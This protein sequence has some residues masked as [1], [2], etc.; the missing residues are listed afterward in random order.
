M[1]A[2]RP[3]ALALESRGLTQ[4]LALEGEG[5]VEALEGEAEAQALAM[6]GE[7]SIRR[8]P[9]GRVAPRAGVGRRWPA[10]SHDADQLSS[11]RVHCWTAGVTAHLLR[12]RRCCLTGVGCRFPSATDPSLRFRP[13]RS[14]FN[15]ITASCCS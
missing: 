7:A 8:W 10:L 12:R 14:P 6:K 15:S 2:L 5:E 3:E 4:V 9:S 1:L 13:S 11:P